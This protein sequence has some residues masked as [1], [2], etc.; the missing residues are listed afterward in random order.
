[1]L[2]IGKPHYQKTDM[3]N[4]SLLWL[5]AEDEFVNQIQRGVTMTEEYKDLIN[6]KFVCHMG[7]NNG[8][9]TQ[10]ISKYA[11]KILAVEINNQYADAKSKDYK[12]ETE[13]INQD[14]FSYLKQYPDIQPDVFY[15][16]SNGC[17]DRIKQIQQIITKD[18]TVMCGIGLQYFQA[19]VSIRDGEA[20]QLTEAQRVQ[21]TYGGNIDY[22]NFP[23]TRAELITGKKS[24]H[25]FYKG[26][27]GC[28]TLTLNPD[29]SP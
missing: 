10:Q 24:K 21:K 8:V 7:S 23:G 19:P 18:V 15:F 1:M 26:F 2:N 28:F 14:V 12:C 22:F 16:W 27:W 4:P 25:G 5:D 13:I 3:Y 20:L 17:E 11:G 29:Q 6:G 9:I